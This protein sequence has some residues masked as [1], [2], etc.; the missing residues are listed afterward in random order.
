MRRNL[1]DAISDAFAAESET[2][3]GPDAVVRPERKVAI[4]NVCQWHL[5]KTL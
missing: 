2:A 3:S 4:G 5:A 1:K